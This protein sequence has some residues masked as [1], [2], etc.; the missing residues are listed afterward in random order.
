VWSPSV[1]P[2]R[3]SGAGHS[4]RSAQWAHPARS[5]RRNRRRDE[6]H[7]GDHRAGRGQHDRIGGA[8]L[9]DAAR[10]DP[11][12]TRVAL[13]VLKIAVV[14]PMPIAS[15]A[16]A[17]PKK[18]GVFQIWRTAYRRSV[19]IPSVSQ[20]PWARL[21]PASGGRGAAQA[22]TRGEPVFLS[23]TSQ[24]GRPE[25]FAERSPVSA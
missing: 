8:H 16:T 25:R 13:I 7:A 20:R 1:C 2:V 19:R 23:R 24:S 18:S 21:V 9:E 12:R 3:R 17:A 22:P 10:E 4:N 14:A 5:D 15:V 6:S 11:G